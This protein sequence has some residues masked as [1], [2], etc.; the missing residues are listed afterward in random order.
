MCSE[1]NL[2]SKTCKAL[3]KDTESFYNNQNMRAGQSKSWGVQT[4]VMQPTKRRGQVPQ[5]SVYNVLYEVTL[6]WILRKIWLHLQKLFVALKYQWHKST[7][8][9]FEKKKLS[10]FKIGLAAIAVFIVFKKDIQFSINMK[11]P[12]GMEQPAKQTAKPMRAKVEELGIGG[13]S[14]KGAAVV[15]PAATT[16]LDEAKVRIYIKRFSKV[17]QAEMLKYGVPASVKMAQA[18]MESWAGQQDETV[19]TNNHFGAPL[20]GRNYDSAWENWR[21]HSMLLREQYAKLFDYGTNYKKWAKG[22]K[23]SGYNKDRNY[24]TKLIDFIEQYQLYQLDEQ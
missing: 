15:Q 1:P 20:A 7:A 3:A 21:V 24:D 4:S 19:A 16:D 13:L 22:L 23:D 11:A 6:G 14:I 9:F 10:W 5:K 17:A 12:T 8:G 18:I 2:Q